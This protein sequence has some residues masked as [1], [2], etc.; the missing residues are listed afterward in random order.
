[1][2]IGSPDHPDYEEFVEMMLRPE[3]QQPRPHGPGVHLGNV[4]GY[5]NRSSPHSR[6]EMPSLGAAAE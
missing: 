3:L 4:L 6:D 2:V 1:M 5:I